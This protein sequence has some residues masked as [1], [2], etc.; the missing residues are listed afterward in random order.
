MYSVKFRDYIHL[1]L[2]E[3]VFNKITFKLGNFTHQKAF[4]SSGGVDGFSL[5]WSLSK[6]GNHG[7][8]I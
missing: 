8:K 2:Y 4:F 7:G 6:V 1:T 5:K 3:L